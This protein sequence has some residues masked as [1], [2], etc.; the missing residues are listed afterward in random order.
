MDR[1]LLEAWAEQTTINTNMEAPPKQDPTGAKKA[2]DIHVVLYFGGFK[3]FD[4]FRN[5]PR[6]HPHKKHHVGSNAAG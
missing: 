4:R 2:A 6:P 3:V 1:C 5:P